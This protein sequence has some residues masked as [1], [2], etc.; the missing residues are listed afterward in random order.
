[1]CCGGDKKFV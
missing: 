1:M